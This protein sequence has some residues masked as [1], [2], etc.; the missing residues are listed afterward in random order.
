VGEYDASGNMVQRYIHGPGVDEP[1]IWYAG[2]SLA[3]P[4]FYHANHQG[5]IIALAATDGS[6]NNIKSY[7]AY[8][9]PDAIN[10]N[11]GRFSYTGQIIL[12][13]LGMYHY[14][15]RIYSPTLGRFLQTDPI[16][17]KDQVNLY[18]YVGN[19]PVNKV[20]PTGLSDVNLFRQGDEEHLESMASQVDM[21]GIFTITGHGGARGVLND[22]NSAVGT[23][24]PSEPRYNPSQLLSVA[25][26][27]GYQRGQTTFIGVCAGNLP[28]NSKGL[29]YGQAYANQSNGKVILPG[30]SLVY[31][32]SGGVITLR[33]VDGKG[34]PTPFSMYTPNG[35]SPT[36]IGNTITIN[37]RTGAAT[38]GNSNSPT[39]VPLKKC[40]SNGICA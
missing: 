37:P 10:A 9:I 2:A 26:G 31:Q 30:G 18:A 28:S 34:N 20:D 15:A 8:G 7:D 23:M 6:L 33:S 16:G 24:D 14:K 12:P 38:I 3:T 19:D 36:S 35:K 21:P 40:N 5:S 17:Y 27:A 4:R 29:S 1:L 11:Y 22:T 39:N 13:E 25:Q 32:R